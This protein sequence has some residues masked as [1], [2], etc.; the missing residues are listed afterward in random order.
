M[1]VQTDRH[2]S[3]TKPVGELHINDNDG[4][5]RKKDLQTK[6]HCQVVTECRDE[7]SV[8]NV[9]LEIL[10]IS[11]SPTHIA[12]LFSTPSEGETEKNLPRIGSKA[13]RVI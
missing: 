2:T 13:F 8:I 1:Y 6:S 7:L 5:K 9:R 4:N 12:S 10:R 11:R 3:K